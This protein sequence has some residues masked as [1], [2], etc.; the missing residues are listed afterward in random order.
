MRTV[1]APA[2]PGLRW[3]RALGGAVLDLLM[4]PACAACKTPVSASGLLCA[5]CWQALVPIGHGRCATCGVPL[6]HAPDEAGDCGACMAEPPGWGRA[7]APQ[8]YAGT[9]RALVLAFKNGRPELAPLMAEAM[10]ADARALAHDDTLVLPVPLHWSRLW[11][12]G[13][14]QAAL[15][16]CRI[17]RALSLDHDV[18]L[19]RR[20]RRTRSS[21]GLSRAARE[22]NLAGAFALRDGGSARVGG[23][24]VLLVDDVL[25]TGA[26]ARAI[27]P[28][29]RRAGAARVDILTFARVVREAPQ[30]HLPPALEAEA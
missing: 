25:T 7:R 16:S 14:N 29:L 4:P 2:R 28:A 17:A 12:R 8:A 3:P 9:G 24:P 23:R 19:L 22:R 30:A 18:D 5:G 20:T 13:Y 10:L 26:T 1:S 11:R 27:R 15:L 21:Q 6:P